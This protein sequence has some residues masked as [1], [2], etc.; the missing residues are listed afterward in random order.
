MNLSGISEQTDFK[1]NRRDIGWDIG[2]NFIE[3][4]RYGKK[5]RPPKSPCLLAQVIGLFELPKKSR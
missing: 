2:P 1:S 4:W 5:K 3:M